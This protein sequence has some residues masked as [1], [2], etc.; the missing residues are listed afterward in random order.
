MIIYNLYLCK[1]KGGGGAKP[2]IMYTF[3]KKGGQSYQYIIPRHLSSD[4]YVITVHI[5]E[6]GDF[7]PSSTSA[8]VIA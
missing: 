1:N 3:A 6:R 7:N 8:N 2:M 4:A 5:G